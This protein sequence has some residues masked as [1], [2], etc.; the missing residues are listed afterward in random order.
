MGGFT[1]ILWSC[2]NSDPKK[3]MEL[4]NSY[5][6]SKSNWNRTLRKE[7]KIS[8][9]SKDATTYDSLCCC[10]CMARQGQYCVKIRTITKR[11]EQFRIIGASGYSTHPQ[12]IYMGWWQIVS[13]WQHLW[14]QKFR[15][16]VWRHPRCYHFHKQV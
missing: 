8:P 7:A 12:N 16:Y 5:S 3:A 10:A 2:I 1:N 13:P 9:N 14:P 4:F 6:N 15:T 11:V